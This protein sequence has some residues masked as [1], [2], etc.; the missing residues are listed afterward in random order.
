MQSHSLALQLKMGTS[1]LPAGRDLLRRCRYRTLSPWLYD[2]VHP[3]SSASSCSI[4]T[5][6]HRQVLCTVWQGT[7]PEA[8]AHKSKACP[9]PTIN[10]IGSS[11]CSQW[12]QYRG[13]DGSHL[14]HIHCILI[15]CLHIQAKDA[16]MRLQI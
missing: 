13:N 2:T 16:K 10:R 8:T 3:P 12:K 9:L 7:L 4:C 1:I 14:L 5:H 15:Y 6:S 11:L